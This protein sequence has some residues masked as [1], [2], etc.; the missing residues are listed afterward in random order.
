M[1]KDRALPKEKLKSL[2]E[3]LRGPLRL[4]GVDSIVTQSSSR[5]EWADNSSCV[6]RTCQ[7]SLERSHLVDNEGNTAF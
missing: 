4:S 2:T 5:Q 7:I 1:D 3:R 6:G